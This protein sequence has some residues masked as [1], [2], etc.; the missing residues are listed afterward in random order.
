MRIITSG[1]WARLQLSL[2]A[3]QAARAKACSATWRRSLRDYLLDDLSRRQRRLRPGQIRAYRGGARGSLRRRRAGC[4]TW[5]P[6]C[7]YPGQCHRRPRRAQCARCRED[8]R[9][10]G[11]LRQRPRHPPD[12]QLA[13]EPAAHL[14]RRTTCSPTAP[15]L[16]AIGCCRKYGLSFDLQLYPGQMD[17]AARS[18]TAA[19]RHADHR[20][21]RRHAGRPRR[22]RHRAM[23]RRA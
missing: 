13:P 14:H 22:R 15:G 2:A 23:A 1:I 4:R 21:P 11:S 3:G 8:A 19:P 9:R 18:R 12:R 17:D 16:P 7:G 20:Q 5:P 10:A 6:Q